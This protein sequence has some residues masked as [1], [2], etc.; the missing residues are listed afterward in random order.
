MTTAA[1]ERRTY[2]PH[3]KDPTYWGCTTKDDLTTIVKSMPNNSD[4]DFWINANTGFPTVY[5]EIAAVAKEYGKNDA[6]GVLRL[7]KRSNVCR[8]EWQSYN[9]LMTMVRQW[10]SVNAETWTEWRVLIPL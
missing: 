3:Y 9:T 10:K 6:F 4:A 2:F 8:V 5:A 1:Y 7:S